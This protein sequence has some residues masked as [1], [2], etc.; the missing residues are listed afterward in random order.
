MWKN[1]G[2]SQD[3]NIIRRMHIAC[4]ITKATNIHSEYV[5]L[6][7]FLLQHWLHERSST[8]RYTYIAS[9]CLCV[10]GLDF[11]GI[12]S[13]AQAYFKERCGLMVV[14]FTLLWLGLG[15][16]SF[17]LLSYLVGRVTSSC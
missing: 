1:A 15:V 9:C 5:I 4:W 7:A 2:R 6:I 3:D 11:K 13:V 10:N 16:L 12:S 17:P 14:I 8:L